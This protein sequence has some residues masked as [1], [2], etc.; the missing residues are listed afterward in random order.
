MK[1]LSI[2]RGNFSAKCPFSL[3]IIEACNSIGDVILQLTPTNGLKDDELNIV[4]SK[5]RVLYLTQKTNQKCRFAAQIL[6]NNDSVN[7]SYGDSAAGEMSGQFIPAST[8]YPRIFIGDGV[9]MGP[10]NYQQNITNPELTYNG[11]EKGLNV[12]FGLFFNFF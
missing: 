3:P 11:P 5:N 8:F 7:C 12:P 10:D 2:I 1:K 6:E 4:N 9:T